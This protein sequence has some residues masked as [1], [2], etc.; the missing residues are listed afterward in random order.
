MDMNIRKKSW[1]ASAERRPPSGAPVSEG[2][3]Q[4]GEAPAVRRFT[5]AFGARAGIGSGRLTDFVLAVNEAAACA[6]S[7][8]PGSARVRLWITGSHAFCEVHGDD[9]RLRQRRGGERRMMV[10]SEA[11][12]M[13][14][15]LLRR[16]S[17]YVSV[18]ADPEGVTVLLSM[19][20]T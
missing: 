3:F 12:A 11:D 8:T 16:L 4:L 17:D 1:Q 18:T 9:K 14:R 19:T 7:R 6:A 15:L 10:S 13:R 20:V 5:R 2:V